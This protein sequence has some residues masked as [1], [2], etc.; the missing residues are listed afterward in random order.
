MTDRETRAVVPGYIQRGGSPTG[1]DRILAS[2]TAAKAVRLLYED[3]PSKAIGIS[4][5]EIVSYDLEEALNM[6]REYD[7]DMFELAETLS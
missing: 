2:L 6:T 3:S 1:K 7:R 5:G 4:E